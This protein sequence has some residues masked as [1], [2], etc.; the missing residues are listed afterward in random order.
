[1][2]QGQATSWL[3]IMGG[4]GPCRIKWRRLTPRA[5]GRF[6]DAPRPRRVLTG[7]AIS[8]VLSASVTPFRRKL[9]S[10]PGYA[11]VEPAINGLSYAARPT[12]C[13]AC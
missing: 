3:A 4:W 11:L 7:K 9:G 2:S 10:R 5:A 1:M 12:T 13:E 8:K 6:R